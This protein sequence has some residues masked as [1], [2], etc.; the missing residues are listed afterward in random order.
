[1]IFLAKLG[2]GVMGTA[3]VAAAA[4]CSEGFIHVKVHEKHV[5]GKNINVTV[6]A[7]LVPATLKFVPNNDLIE[8]SEN[9]CP[10]LPIIDAAIRA[11][12]DCPDGLLV[13]VVDSRDHVR[14][15]KRGGSIVVDVND[16]ADTVHVSV[17]LRA[18]ESSIHEIARAK[19]M[20]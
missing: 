11:L 10:Y 13:E 9:L 14:V 18:A 5:G 6:P 3:A 15:A 16:A 1:M 2:L 20:D 8:A 12:E 17:P 4:L 19:A 7:A